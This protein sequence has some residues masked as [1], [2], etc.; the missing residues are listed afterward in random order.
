MADTGWLDFGT[1]SDDSSVGSLA[2]T[3]P[4]YA[5]TLN[6]QRASIIG[7]YSSGTFYSHYLKCTNPQGLPSF[8]GKVITGVEVDF[9]K[10]ES[11]GTPTRR[12]WDE[13]VKLVVGGSVVGNNYAD[14]VTEWPVYN[15]SYYITYGGPTDLWGL[16]ISTSDI[17]S[18][19]GVVLE[20]RM[21]TQNSSFQVTSYVDHV[22]VKIY[23]EEDTSLFLGLL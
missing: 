7:P 9:Y 8:S 19:F 11:T 16:S 13:V 22:R 21:N 23:Y 20:S 14:T 17:D 4:S 3:N 10:E 12:T 2:W 18:N 15:T 5:Q 1:F 6:S